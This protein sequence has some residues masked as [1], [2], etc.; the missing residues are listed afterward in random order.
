MYCRTR[1]DGVPRLAGRVDAGGSGRWGT[2]VM[3]VPGTVRTMVGARGT[4]PGADWV[5]IRSE[6]DE[7]GPNST[8]MGPNSMK[9]RHQEN[10]VRH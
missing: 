6:L 10:T 8:K 7:N 1:A 2:R 9:L 4:G 3:V 5:R